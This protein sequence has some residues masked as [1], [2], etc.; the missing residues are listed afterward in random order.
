MLY[1]KLPLQ[2]QYFVDLIADSDFEV[3]RLSRL[4]SKQLKKIEEC[5]KNLK[6][7]VGMTDPK[8]NVYA[9]KPEL[10]LLLNKLTMEKNKDNEDDFNQLESHKK[11]KNKKDR[12]TKE[13][14]NSLDH[15]MKKKDDK[16]DPGQSVLA[17]IANF[18]GFGG[19]PA[20]EHQNELR[21]KGEKS[22]KKKKTG[23]AP[24]VQVKFERFLH[25]DGY[26]YKNNRKFVVESFFDDLNYGDLVLK[27][28]NEE[29]KIGPNLDIEAFAFLSG[30]QMFNDKINIYSD[31]KEIST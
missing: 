10:N 3:E 13:K 22:K 31:Q 8:G 21:N 5:N 2:W 30:F 19:L 18:I 4:L 12:E 23:E 1:E 16:I 25:E 28:E 7:H 26:Y 15:K 27:F 14:K 11:K 29:S 9:L 24:P 6:E 20:T 17:R